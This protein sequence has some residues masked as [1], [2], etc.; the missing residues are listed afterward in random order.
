MPSHVQRAIERLLH[1]QG[2]FTSQDLSVRTGLSRQAL[3]RHLRNGVE[4]GWLVRTGRARATRYLRAKSEPFERTYPVQGL[5]EH[6]VWNELE[7]WLLAQPRPPGDNALSILQYVL[8]ETVNNAIDHSRSEAVTVRAELGSEATLMTV[9]D[10]GIGAFENLRSHLGLEDH[11]HAVQ[12]LSKGKVTTDPVHHTGE[13]LFFS[14]KAVDH[15][16][17]AANSLEWLVDNT[18]P[19][20]TV[21]ETARRPGT[22]VRL[23]Q[24]HESGRTLTSIFAAYTHDLT[25]DTTRCVVRLF[26]HG[27]PFVSRSEARRLTADLERF[28]NVIV[29]FH[30][31]EAVG[32]GFVDEVFR[33]WASSHPEVRLTPVNMSSTV[34]FMVRRGLGPESSEPS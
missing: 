17:L 18:L 19:D 2:S 21:R 29:D 28:R 32:Q 24:P 15:F 5:E 23:E 34:E 6:A 4:Q 7:P 3:Q 13:G 9:H 8:T 26:E 30:S 10:E 14:S 25:F 27:T 31:V 11:L 20:H 16:S 12:E 22:T 1:Q 33:V